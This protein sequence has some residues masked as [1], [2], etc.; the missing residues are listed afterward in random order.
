MTPDADAGAVGAQR[1]ALPTEDPRACER[2][3][4]RRF[5]RFW[6]PYRVATIRSEGKPADASDQHCPLLQRPEADA[7]GLIVFQGRLLLR[8]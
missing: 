6:T 7:E 2:P 1:E 3:G 4:C 8:P 5:R